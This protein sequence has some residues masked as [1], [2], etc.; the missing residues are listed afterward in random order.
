MARPTKPRR[1]CQMPEFREF[2]PTGPSHESSAGTSIHMTLEELETL[3]LMDLEDHTQHEGA[4]IMGVSRST[5]QRLYNDARKKVAKS[6]VGG[7]TLT[8][9]GGHY[10]LCEYIETSPCPK[11]TRKND[12]RIIEKLAKKQP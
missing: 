2:H 5:F 4:D 11:C 10:E 12:P 9:E 1:I 3:R 6:L 8:I 7:Y